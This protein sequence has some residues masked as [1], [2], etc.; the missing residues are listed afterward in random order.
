[1]ASLWWG[2]GVA[3][4]ES[5]FSSKILSRTMN[6]QWT[7]SVTSR[8]FSTCQGDHGP[9]QETPVKTQKVV[10]PDVCHEGRDFGATVHWCECGRSESR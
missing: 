3:I 2:G 4:Y 9:R 5:A 8:G 1:M 7:W 6:A 10:Y